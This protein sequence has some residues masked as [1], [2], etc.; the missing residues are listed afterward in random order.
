[1]MDGCDSVLI[2]P[3]IIIV[4]IYA[5]DLFQ[6]SFVSSCRIVSDISL[7]LATFENTIF[8]RIGLEPLTT[9]LQMGVF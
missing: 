5:S 9:S 8:R 4:T 6:A 1:M 7:F 3:V 2:V